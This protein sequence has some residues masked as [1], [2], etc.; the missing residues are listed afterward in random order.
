MQGAIKL[1]E[2]PF[3]NTNLEH[4]LPSIQV[5]HQ[6]FSQCPVTGAV[7]NRF[8]AGTYIRIRMTYVAAAA[9][10]KDAGV[11]VYTKVTFGRTSPDPLKGP[12]HTIGVSLKHLMLQVL[13]SQVAFP[14]ILKH[15]LPQPYSLMVGR[16]RCT[17]HRSKPQI[18]VGMQSSGWYKI[19]ISGMHTTITT[20]LLLQVLVP[21]L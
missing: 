11:C 14:P 1:S 18:R 4:A 17:A 3:K 16:S 15:K 10:C 7:R 8:K 2:S 13:F 6:K 9:T 20:S 21:L 5:R 12:V 19:H